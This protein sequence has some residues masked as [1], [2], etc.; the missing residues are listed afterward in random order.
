MGSCLIQSWC[1]DCLPGGDMVS[2][3]GPRLLSS[4]YPFSD[5]KG[6]TPAP[7]FEPAPLSWYNRSDITNGGEESEAIAIGE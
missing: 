1:R 2:T 6:A 7:G 5:L 4:A 3:R